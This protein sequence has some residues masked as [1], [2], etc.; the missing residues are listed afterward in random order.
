MDIKA[1]LIYGLIDAGI[2]NGKFYLVRK[3]G[4]TLGPFDNIFPFHNGIGAVKKGGKYNF[5]NKD[6]ELIFDVWFDEV[7]RDYFKD[8]PIVDVLFHGYVFQASANGLLH[9][10]DKILDKASLAKALLQ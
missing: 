9:F 6:L 10:R 3:D 4:K 5:V 8:G 2:K 1:S 7:D